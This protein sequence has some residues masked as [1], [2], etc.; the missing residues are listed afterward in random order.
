M[1]D[2][3]ESDEME[4]AA[5]RW[6]PGASLQEI[7]I[8]MEAARRVPGDE[9]TT[10]LFAG[11]AAARREGTDS[12]DHHAAVVAVMASE[13][14]RARLPAAYDRIECAQRLLREREREE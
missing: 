1:N 13:S 2:D 14:G 12:E 10:R 7:G 3:A 5:V 8:A 9:A 6:A 4:I 11:A